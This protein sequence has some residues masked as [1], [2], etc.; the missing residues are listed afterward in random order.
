MGA[1]EDVAARTGQ[2]ANSGCLVATVEWFINTVSS[3]SSTT[4]G[5]NIDVQVNP[6]S[7]RI[8]LI[9]DHTLM[10]KALANMLNANPNFS[11]VAEA[12]C[13]GSGIVMFQKLRPDVTL[14]DVSM[15]G[16]T[17][18]EVMSLIHAE[19]PSA[20]VL[21]LSSSYAEEDIVQALE[22]GACGYLFKS[23]RP[24]ELTKA[25]I[26]AHAGRRVLSPEVESNNTERIATAAVSDRE[27]EILNLLRKGMNNA[28]I[29]LLLC[30]SKH[31]AKAH[32]A[33]ILR[34]LHAADRA[35]AVAIAFEQCL[36]KF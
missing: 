18:I 12:A 16:M 34:K 19:F 9:D 26:A 8:L 31:T 3:D 2:L 23:A 11:V 21:M 33:S 13:G 7:I 17:G 25:I 20:R 14:L 36:L 4:L 24:I 10:R 22:A 6:S 32:V 30:I 27:I 35:E 29:S 28:D 5:G 1:I 15:P